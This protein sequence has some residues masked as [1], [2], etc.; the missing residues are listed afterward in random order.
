MGWVAPQAEPHRPSR[1]SFLYTFLSL[2]VSAFVV[3]LVFIASTIVSVGFTMWC[4]TITEKGTVPHRCALGLPSA[5]ILA[6]SFAGPTCL[7]PTPSPVHTC[8]PL[9]WDLLP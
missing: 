5:S 7:P 9:P 4:D 1:S 8:Q 6:H 2:L 3:F